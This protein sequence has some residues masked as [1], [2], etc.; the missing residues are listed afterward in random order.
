VKRTTCSTCRAGSRRNRREL[1]ERERVEQ[2]EEAE[3][4]NEER[5]SGSLWEVARESATVRETG[6]GAAHPERAL[7]AVERGGLR[8][9][10]LCFGSA[11]PDR[12]TEERFAV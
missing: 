10:E 6:D 2:D 5:K 4:A 7:V 1:E 11:S 8:Q 3:A 9:C 12:V